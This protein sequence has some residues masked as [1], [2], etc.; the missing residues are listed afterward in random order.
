MFRLHTL[1]YSVEILIVN[2]IHC[3]LIERAKVFEILFKIFSKP[4]MFV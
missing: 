1:L 2:C 3:M 4:F